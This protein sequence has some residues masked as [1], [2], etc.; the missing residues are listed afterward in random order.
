MSEAL[1]AL[2]G[3]RVGIENRRLELPTFALAVPVAMSGVLSDERV[4]IGNKGDD[5]GSA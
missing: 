2:E 1:L 4:G 5:E 3:R